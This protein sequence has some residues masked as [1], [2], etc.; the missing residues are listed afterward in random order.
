[1]KGAKTK[2]P[3]FPS[4]FLLMKNLS[5]L[6][7]PFIFTTLYSQFFNYPYAN[8]GYDTASFPDNSIGLKS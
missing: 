4:L 5:S 3:S 8:Q 7:H 6:N 2:Y 1:M